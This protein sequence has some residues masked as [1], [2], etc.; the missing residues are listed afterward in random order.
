MFV[1]SSPALLPRWGEGS[2]ILWG[3]ELVRSENGRA[4]LKGPANPQASLESL[5]D[6]SRQSS[7]RRGAPKRMKVVYCLAEAYFR[8]RN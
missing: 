2:R 4:G 6:V 3:L 1:P 8:N 5:G 7:M